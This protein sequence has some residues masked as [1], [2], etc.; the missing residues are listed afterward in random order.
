MDVDA[1]FK[2]E[3]LQAFDLAAIVWRFDVLFQQLVPTV[4][5]IFIFDAI[6]PVLSRL[7]S[8]FLLALPIRLHFVLIVLSGLEAVNFSLEVAEAFIVVH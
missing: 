1:L 6:D 4:P 7:L 5:D 3:S 2:H 8:V